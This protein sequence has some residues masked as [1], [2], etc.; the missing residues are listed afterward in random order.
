MPMFLKFEKLS[1]VIG[2]E[3]LGGESHLLELLG[4]RSRHL[5]TSDSDGWCLKEVECVLGGK[6]DEL[7]TD[8]VT[9]ETGLDG[10][11]VTSFLD[12]LDDGLNI[13]GLD[14]TEVDDLDLDAVL[15]LE[16]FG[17]GERLADATREGDDGE[18]LALTLN[19]GLAELRLRLAEEWISI[20]LLDTYGNDKVVLL[21]FLAHGERK[22]VEKPF[23]VD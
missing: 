7:S 18:V 6:G 22:T 8:T 11:H 9:W 21:G 4:V 5:S 19:L 13:E 2:D 15:G 12:R 10:H 23:M 20:G 14:G 17:S 16:N 3:V 1:S